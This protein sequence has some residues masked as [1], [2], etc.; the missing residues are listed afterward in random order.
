M[1]F[2]DEETKAIVDEAHRLGRKV[3]A[4]AMGRE[5]IDAALS[6]GVDTIEHGDGLDDELMDSMVKQRRLLVSRRSTSASTSA[7]A[8]AAGAPIWVDD[9]RPREAKAFGKAVRKG[10]KIA[11]GTDAG[12][13]A[14][15][16]NRRRSSRTWSLRHDADAGD[17]VGDARGR[18]VARAGGGYRHRGDPA[19]RR[20]AGP[21]TS[22]DKRERDG[23]GGMRGAAVKGAAAERWSMAEFGRGASGRSR[24][25]MRI[26]RAARSE[27]GQA[28][29][30]SRAIAEAS[31]SLSAPLHD[32]PVDHG[33]ALLVRDPER[34][35][36]LRAQLVHRLALLLDP[37]EVLLVV[38]AAAHLARALQDPV[39]LLPAEDRAGGAAPR[40]A[41]IGPRS[42]AQAR[43]APTGS[44]RSRRWPP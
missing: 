17:P 9:G 14:W 6:A 33:G 12:G 43:A 24:S 23:P 22:R 2:T 7:E 35:V 38:P 30:A 3:A 11:Y 1:N 29:D 16:E 28:V 13:F 37:G 44:G 42:A 32:T 18:G 4:H 27:G 8:A 36:L 15:T 21:A 34:R 5:G 41:F 40:R 25:R 19:L 26:M 20:D 10:V 39:R 31:L